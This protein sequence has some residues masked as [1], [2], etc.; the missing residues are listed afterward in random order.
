MLGPNNHGKSNILSAVE[1]ALST[2]AKPT[3]DDFFCFRGNDDTLWVELTFVSLTEQERN[4]FKKYLRADDSI[5]VRKTGRLTETGTVEVSYNGYLQ[6]ADEWWLRA[7]SVMLLTKREEVADTP[8]SDMVPKSGRLSKAHIEEAQIRYID[9]HRDE[10]TFEEILE[11]GPF[12][13]QKN[14]GGG[15][16]PDFYLIPAVRDLADE[17]KTKT[18][19][20]FGRLL[21]RAVREMAERDPRF[22]ELR[23]GMEDLVKT[24][25]RSNEGTDERPEQLVS[26]EGVLRK[27]LSSWGV[28]VDIEVL[29]PA[30]EK[31]FELGTN[32]HI[33][34]GV[35]TLA[36]QK[37]HGLQ[38]AVIFALIR[39]WAIALRTPA[40]TESGTVP[41]AS[42]E[43]L[44]F[45]MEEPELFLHPHAQRRLAQ[46]IAEIANTAEHQVLVCTHSSHFIDLDKYQNLG[47]VF[48]ESP[49]TGTQMRQCTDELFE[50]ETTADRKN[51]FH[52]ACWVN[53]D[54]GEMFFAK[55]IAFVEGETEKTLFPFLA[56]RMGCLDQDV[57]IIDCGSKHNL[58]LYI[59]IANAFK[60][61]YVV[62]HDED[63]LPNPIPTE[64]SH[65]KRREKQRTYEL[66]Q[67]IA[68]AV[69]VANGSVEML[70]PDLEHV[71]G[72]SLAQG[73]KKGK[74]LAALD[75]FQSIASDDIPVRLKEVVRILYEAR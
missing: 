2:S 50:D 66:N 65:D 41:R 42:S 3:V 35:R 31:I 24:L 62:I 27:E 4:T 59:A 36:E 28:S 52:M 45:A 1:F 9:Q 33:D 67:E 69:N 26:L 56:D 54:R 48:R 32:L 46:S 57:S 51:R 63:P 55:R 7:D 38:R 61:S 44:V 58:P 70:A 23:E 11:T 21:N 20:A 39:A 74:P 72:V 49:T 10:L 18:T 37:G 14:I 40:A 22:R 17:T 47:I 5:R 71:A 30:L 12:L 68:D 13:G 6:Q 29:P 64:W 8:L 15:V 53:P 60:L 75:H 25:N 43:S 34:D 16:L 73:T 19:A